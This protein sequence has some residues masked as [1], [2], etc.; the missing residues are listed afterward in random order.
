MTPDAMAVLRRKATASSSAASFGAAWADAKESAYLS[1]PMENFSA[2]VML[3]PLAASL[4]AVSVATS[5]FWKLSPV[6]AALMGNW[7][8]E[9]PS[10]RDLTLEARASTSFFFLASFSALGKMVPRCMES[11]ESLVDW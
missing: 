5:F 1:K 6:S 8:L 7:N 4:M 3:R 9:T 11:R 2:R 10:T